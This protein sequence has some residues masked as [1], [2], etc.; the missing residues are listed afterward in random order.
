MDHS[1]PP[2]ATSCV[3]VSKAQRRA[4]PFVFQPP[5]ENLWRFLDQW[6]KPVEVGP[7]LKRKAVFGSQPVKAWTIA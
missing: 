5:L 4:G 3:L 1:T 7:T 2:I 6:W